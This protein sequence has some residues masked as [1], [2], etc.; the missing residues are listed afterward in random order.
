MS[1]D[2]K[3]VNKELPEKDCTDIIFCYGCNI[4]VGFFQITLKSAFFCNSNDERF[5]KRQNFKDCFGQKLTHWA[6]INKPKEKTK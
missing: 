3:D 5:Y 1:I 4:E 6:Y 2:W